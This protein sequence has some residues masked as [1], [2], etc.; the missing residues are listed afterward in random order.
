MLRVCSVLTE[1]GAGGSCMGADPLHRTLK[2]CALR[3]RL[4]PFEDN[5]DA[6]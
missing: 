4:K 6:S 3:V 2:E 1:V 5:L